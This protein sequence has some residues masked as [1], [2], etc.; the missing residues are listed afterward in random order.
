[1][2]AI[3]AL[4]ASTSVFGGASATTFARRA[5]RDT[6]PPAIPSPQMLSSPPPSYGGPQSPGSYGGCNRLFDQ[7]GGAAWSGATCCES[8]AVCVAASQ[9]YSQCVVP[10]STPR[11]NGPAGLCSSQFGQCGGASWD[12]T[13]C[14][15]PG[16]ECKSMTT[17]Y[18][19]CLPIASAP[20]GEPVV[21]QNGCALLFGQC[22]GSSWNGTTCCSAG[23]ECSSSGPDYSQCVTMMPPSSPVAPGSCSVEFDQCGGSSWAGPD[24]CEDGLKCIAHDAYYSQC[25]KQLSTVPAAPNAVDADGCGMS[26]SQCGGAE[27]NGTSCCTEDHTCV[28]QSEYYSQCLPPV[29]V[30]VPSPPAVI[31]SDGCTNR[32]SQCGGLGFSDADLCCSGANECVVG[33]PYYSQCLPRPLGEGIVPWW[34]TCG[35]RGW[36]GPTECEPLSVCTAYGTGIEEYH[37]CKPV[38]A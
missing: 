12:G 6:L 23:A 22:G 14:C 21:D 19:Q 37:I 3:I 33:N 27:W 34:G 36:T 15:A 32:W 13:T 29:A 35:G 25:L 20:T 31:D 5:L 11:G 4:L 1:M 2:W 8:G 9:Y 18:S 17:D 10:S 16:T 26:W 30:S 28:V 24:C 7:C 38:V